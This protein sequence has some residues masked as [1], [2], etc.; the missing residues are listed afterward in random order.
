M[1]IRYIGRNRQKKV[2]G[3]NDF[4]R[5]EVR[6]DEKSNGHEIF[7]KFRRPIV[8]DSIQYNDVNN[9]RMGYIIIERSDV[10]TVGYK[11]PR[12][13]TTEFDSKNIRS[14]QIRY[15]GVGLLQY[16]PGKMLSRQA[17]AW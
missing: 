15:G 14:K 16:I 3:R 7:F 5:I 1:Y 13:I 9:K 4:D 8:D 10:K 11:K 12:P 2:S 17:G 6:Y